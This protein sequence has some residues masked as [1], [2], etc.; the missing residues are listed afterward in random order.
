[1]EEIFQKVNRF[2]ARGLFAVTL[3]FSLVSLLWILYNNGIADEKTLTREWTDESGAKVD[4]LKFYDYQDGKSVFTTVDKILESEELCFSGRNV[5]VDVYVNGEKVYS[6]DREQFWAYGKSFGT[7]W[8][9]ISIPPKAGN[10]K[11][12]IRG[13]AV[14]TNS[15]GLV[16]KVEISEGTK[17]IY[18]VF[19]EGYI[20]FIFS[21]I[22]EFFG[23]LLAIIYIFVHKYYKLERD[24]LYLAIGTFLCAQWCGAETEMWQLILG[25]SSAF[26]LLSYLSLMAIPIPF[27]MLASTRLSGKWKQA[28]CLYTFVTEINFALTTILHMSGI[29]EY[30]YTVVTVHI[31]L[32]LL[33]PLAIKVLIGYNNEQTKKYKGMLFVTFVLLV[34]FITLGI[35]R[36]RTGHYTDFSTYI[37]ISL[38][39]FLFLMLVYQIIGINAVFVKGMQSELLHE[40]A[41]TDHLTKFYNRSGFA[42]HRSGYEEYETNHKPLGVVQFDVNDLKKVNDSQGHEKGDELI[43]LVSSGIYQSFGA[44]GKCY[45]MGGDEFLVLLTGDN[46]TEDYHVGMTSLRLYCDYANSVEDRSFDVNIANGFA[47]MQ[48]GELLSE[49]IERADIRMYE[50]KKEMK[51]KNK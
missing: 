6:D 32:G 27:G 23:I 17:Y 46:P 2:L 35:V 33:F 26:H 5:Y 21:I 41:L 18:K 39:L 44:K 31:L 28:A 4:E 14:Y 34:V 51:S 47:L 15:A 10:T 19:S 12:E 49:T 13:T 25:H 1:M 45:R 3:F 40:L 16:S 36:Y 29:L 7:K 42:E 30:H 24:F 8:Y 48:E 20:A 22:W 38:S 37:R 9:I 43:C 50:N 11:I